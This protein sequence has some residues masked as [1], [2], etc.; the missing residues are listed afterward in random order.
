MLTCSVSLFA[1]VGPGEQGTAVAASFVA[2]A[3]GNVIGIGLSA[4]LQQVVL[5]IDLRHRLSTLVDDP[6]IDPRAAQRLAE[7][8][9]GDTGAGEDGVY[10]Q[11]QG[12]VWVRDC[13]G[14][15]HDG[16]VC[17]HQGEAFVKCEVGI[18]SDSHDR[19]I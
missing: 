1:V 5:A 17:L 2:R 19:Y 14:C 13:D 3:M 11:H 4:P 18:S 15:D 6:R 9:L 12:G 8:R 16:A 10:D 7:P